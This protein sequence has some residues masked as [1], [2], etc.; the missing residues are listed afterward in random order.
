MYDVEQLTKDLLQ[1][2]KDNLNTEITKIQTQKGNDFELK[3]IAE[4]TAYYPSLDDNIL[5]FD[6]FVYY[7]IGDNDILSNGPESSDNLE[8]FF[9]VVFTN[10]NDDDNNYWRSLRYIRALR[11]VFENNYDS[12]P[13]AGDLKLGV[14]T[15]QNLKDLDDDTFYKLSGITV[16]ASLA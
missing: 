5:E 11:K 13:E 15:P 1:L 16:T 7:G 8:I 4:P 3:L 12:I 2:V 14:I 10:E 9:T 6:P